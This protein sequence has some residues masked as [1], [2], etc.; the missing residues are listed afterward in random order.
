MVAEPWWYPPLL[1]TYPSS[2]PLR[3]PWRPVGLTPRLGKLQE[4]EAE[5]RVWLE[6][7]GQAMRLAGDRGPHPQAA[8][9]GRRVL[10][11]RRPRRPLRP[12]GAFRLI[13]RRAPPALT[14]G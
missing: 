8:S 10:L 5:T 1:Q 13:P 7:E 3:K 6:E 12:G 4:L 11:L 14:T 9:A 2:F